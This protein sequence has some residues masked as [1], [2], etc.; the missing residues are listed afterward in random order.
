MTDETFKV[1][2]ENWEAFEEFV[3]NHP[4]KQGQLGAP[5]YGRKQSSKEETK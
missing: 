3:R 4:D 2:D 5:L 1:I